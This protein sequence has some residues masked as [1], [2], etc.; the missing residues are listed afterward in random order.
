MAAEQDDTVFHQDLE[1]D[2]ED[3]DDQSSQSQNDDLED[4][5]EIENDDT[6][7]ENDDVLSEELLEDDDTSTSAA[8]P[9]AITAVTIASIPAFATT[10]TAVASDSTPDA[11]K[12]QRVPPETTTIPSQDSKRPQFDDTRRLFQRLWTDEDEIE[13]LQGFLDYTTTKGT[14]N[15]HHNDTALFYDQIKSKLQLDFNKNQL[16]EKLRRLK[17]KYRNVLSKINSGKDFCFKSSHDQATFEI[18]RKIWSSTGKIAGFSNEDGHNL[19]DDDGGNPNPNLNNHTVMMDGDVAVKI[20]DQKSTP[21]SRKRSRSRSA[22]GVRTVEKRVLNDGF[23]GDETNVN[24][25]GSGNGNMSSVIEETM[26]SCLS[27]LF[28]ELLSSMA[29]AGMGGVGRGVGGLAMNAMPLSF[30]VG[31][32][33]MMDEKWRKQHILELEVYS[34]R[35]ELVQDQIRA[36]LDE[37]RSMGD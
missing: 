25:D 7:P 36:Q 11:S 27:P 28:K 16:V 6:L 15:N 4:D 21:R 20:E 2:D 33:M 1:V 13:L 30:G 26:K 10:I 14:V 12:R 17:K 8:V 23:V 35:L 34:K 29:G 31:D 19:D 32:V 24:G 37:L 18:S 9:T 5:L 22:V 3:E